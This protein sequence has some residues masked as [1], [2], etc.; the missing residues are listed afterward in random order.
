MVTFEEYLAEVFASTA[1]KAIARIRLK[2]K[3]A[4]PDARRQYASAIEEFKLL[5]QATNLHQQLTHLR[6]AE[7]LEHLGDAYNKTS[8][9]AQ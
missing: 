5:D 3:A 1:D 2:M 8:A 7:R 4:S 6:V 9:T